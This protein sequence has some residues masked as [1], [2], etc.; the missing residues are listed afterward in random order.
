MKRYPMRLTRIARRLFALCAAVYVAAVLGTGIFVWN[1]EPPEALPED[2]LIIVLGAGIR[3]DGSASPASRERARTAAELFLDGVGRRILITGGPTPRGPGAVATAM[4]AEIHGFGIDSS[5]VAVE[6]ESRSTLQNALFTRDMI[7]P[8]AADSPVILI[9]QRFHLPRSW[10]SFRWAGH[11]DLTLYPSDPAPGRLSRGL[12][13]Q[14]MLEGAK[15]PMNMVRAAAASLGI[16]AGV[17]EE[18]YIPLLD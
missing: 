12:F 2:A 18:L 10:V 6:T 4:A 1:Y 16:A 8:E 3:A 11:S 13:L 5:A 17:P 15:W 7:G 9:T 14:L